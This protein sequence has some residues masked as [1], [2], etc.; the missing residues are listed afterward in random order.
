MEKSMNPR[1]YDTEHFTF[2]YLNKHG[3]HA[4]TIKRKHAD[5]IG[6]NHTPPYKV[7]YDAAITD[8]L[9][10]GH[11]SCVDIQPFF[12]ETTSADIH[13]HKV[14]QFFTPW[15]KTTTDCRQEIEFAI[16]RYYA[17]EAYNYLDLGPD[18]FAHALKNQQ[19]TYDQILERIPELYAKRENIEK[20]LKLNY[21]D[22]GVSTARGSTIFDTAEFT[23]VMSETNIEHAEKPEYLWTVT[24]LGPTFKPMHGHNAFV[25]AVGGENASNQACF[26]YI[27]AEQKKLYGVSPVDLDKVEGD[28]LRLHNVIAQ[29]ELLLDIPF[30]KTAIPQDEE[31]QSAH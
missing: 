6:S 17:L 8:G 13:I 14:A 23:W 16:K 15:F 10:H 18:Q 26:E 29:M 5:M 31:T 2:T 20:I 30:S 21:Q 19:T 12:S 3:E 24:H 7:Y 27:M 4:L 28:I 25:D 22:K 1:N 11:A 9:T